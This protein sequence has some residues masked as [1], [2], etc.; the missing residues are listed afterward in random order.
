M[1]WSDLEAT[2]KVWLCRF[3]LVT[4]WHSLQ[5][6]SERKKMC[7]V[8]LATVGESYVEPIS[9]KKIFQSDASKTCWNFVTVPY[10]SPY[11]Y[12]V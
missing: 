5:F 12:C 6:G 10:E 2:L 3:H 8:I 11:N 4:Q 7:D 9:L 1:I